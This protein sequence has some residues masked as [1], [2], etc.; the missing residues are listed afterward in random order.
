MLNFFILLKKMVQFQTPI[1]N[2]EVFVNIVELKK[3]GH[4]NMKLPK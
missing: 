3:I 2:V 1:D 4:R